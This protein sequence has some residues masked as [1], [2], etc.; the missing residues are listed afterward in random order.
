MIQI[1]GRKSCRTSRKA[2]RFFSDRG[3]KIQDLDLKSHPLSRGELEHI[4]RTVEPEEL[5]DEEGTFYQ[6]NGYA[7]REFDPLDEIL[8]HPELLK[9]PV[10][11]YSGKASCGDDESAWDA[12]AR[13]YR[14]R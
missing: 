7:W 3:I 14:N 2:R 11:R 5:I 4:S 8:E 1:I 12:F 9:T 13:E 6:K 10:V